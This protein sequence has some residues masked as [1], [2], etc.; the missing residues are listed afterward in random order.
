[1]KFEGSAVPNKSLDVV[2]EDPL[3]KEIFSDI[4]QVNGIRG[5]K[6]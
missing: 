1:M 4:I 2:L 6:I 5:C 3:G